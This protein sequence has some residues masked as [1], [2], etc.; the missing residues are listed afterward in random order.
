MNQIYPK[1]EKFPQDFHCSRTYVRI[2]VKTLRIVVCC[3]PR[4]VI[5]PTPSHF[6]LNQRVFELQWQIGNQVVK[7][8]LL[9]QE[10]RLAST[11]WART[12]LCAWKPR[13]PNIMIKDTKNHILRGYFFGTQR[14]RIVSVY[15]FSLSNLD[16][17]ASR[18]TYENRIC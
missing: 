9:D 11:S 14:A 4:S 3:A 13:P 8:H 18:N 10:K 1:T 6:E 12:W 17:L 5:G 2:L 15:R 7:K 16:Y